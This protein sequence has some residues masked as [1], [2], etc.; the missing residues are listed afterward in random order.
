MS[1]MYLK[2]PMAAL[3]LGVSVTRLGSL[4]RRRAIPAPQKDSSGDYIWSPADLRRARQALGL[5]E[6]ESD[7]ATVP[8]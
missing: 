2:T 3:D 1:N 5:T 6:P 7:R 8:A 4:L